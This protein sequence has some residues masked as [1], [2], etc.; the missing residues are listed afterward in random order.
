MTLKSN[1][2]RLLHMYIARL[3]KLIKNNVMCYLEIKRHI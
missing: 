3:H 1:L 2:Q